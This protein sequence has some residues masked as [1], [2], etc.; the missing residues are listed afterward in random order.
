MNPK[1]LA[2][3]AAPSAVAIVAKPSL[4]DLI[5]DADDDD[6]DDDGCPD[7]GVAHGA[8]HRWGCRSHGSQQN[9]VSR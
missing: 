4:A 8:A 5:G 2:S 7:C 3:L 9:V 1:L 6:A